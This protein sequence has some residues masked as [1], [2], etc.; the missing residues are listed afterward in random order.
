VQS[1]VTP[2]A[3]VVIQSPASGGSTPSP[4]TP[5]AADQINMS[6]AVIQNSP[7]DLAS[8][9]V[10]SA[11]TRL[12]LRASGVHAEFS[13]QNSWPSV[14]PPGWSGDLQ[15]TLGM[16]LNL[17]GKWYCSAVV[18]FWRGLYESGGE[19]SGYARNWFYD[20]GR[21][22][23]MSGHQPARSEIIGFFGCAGDCRNNTAG[24]LSPVKE[25]T[26]VVLVPMP[27][28]GGMSQTFSIR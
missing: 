16:C 8:W 10:T 1:F 17:S 12:D 19:P 5:V 22:G 2:A 25:R 3:P 27:D 14:R 24:D 6:G 21:W 26:N 4:G 18:E 7:F 11:I 9:P 23:P 20:Q 15:W 28:D 13:A